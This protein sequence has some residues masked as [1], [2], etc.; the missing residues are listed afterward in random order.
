M[1]WEYKTNSGHKA[2]IASGSV[3]RA[4]AAGVAI[5]AV[6]IGGGGVDPAPP[7]ASA[8]APWSLTSPDRKP[9]RNLESQTILYSISRRKNLSQLRIRNGIHLTPPSRKTVMISMKQSKDGY[10]S[11]NRYFNILVPGYTS[12]P[13][14]RGSYSGS[15]FQGL[16]NSKVWEIK[17]L[18]RSIYYCILKTLLDGW[19]EFDSSDD[20]G[21]I[22]G[23][24]L[25]ESPS[26]VWD[27]ASCMSTYCR[28]DVCIPSCLSS[29]SYT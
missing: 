15:E 16:A 18:F 19:S 25:Y 20:N 17:V 14:L 26:S 8:L 3:A 5:G 11:F 6:E 29:L 9:Y 13:T 24:M 27:K 23:S 28:D 10:N 4:M 12:Q 22:L 1:V 21:R 7:A 2:T